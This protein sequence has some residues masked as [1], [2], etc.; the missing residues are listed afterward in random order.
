MSDNPYIDAH[1]RIY[2]L[3]QR[4][5]ELETSEWGGRADAVTKFEEIQ[6]KWGRFGLMEMDIWNAAID[7]AA[8]EC[9]EVARIFASKASQ[10]C[11]QRILA[12]KKGG[13]Q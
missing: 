6:K 3:E 5:K 11:K 9:E 13:T 10:A 8:E 7:T 4:I 1:E 2:R 12:L